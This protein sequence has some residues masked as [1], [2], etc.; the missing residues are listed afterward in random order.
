MI[1][2]GTL[3]PVEFCEVHLLDEHIR[4]ARS[5]RVEPGWR[6]ASLKFTFM[7]YSV[8]LYN[9]AVFGFNTFVDHLRQL[10]FL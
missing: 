9:K 1:I 2:S 8:F 4:I 3:D 5:Q 10:V 7:W 6:L